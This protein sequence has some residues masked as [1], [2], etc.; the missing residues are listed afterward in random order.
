MDPGQV[1][2]GARSV[3]SLGVPYTASAPIRETTDTV[4]AARIA[5]FAQ[6]LDYHD[7]IRNRL[8]ALWAYLLQQAPGA[9]G[10]YYVDTGPVL[11]REL[12]QRAGLGW[13]GKNTCLINKRGGSFFFLAEIITDLALES[14]PPASSHCGTCRACLDAC[15]TRA[16]IA[17]NLLDARRCIA[18]LTIEHRGPIPRD[19]RPRMG[20]W[21]FGCDVCQQV[22]PW[23]RHPYAPDPAFHD[24]HPRDES[25]IEL[26]GLGPEEFN[27]IFRGTAVKRAKRRGFLRNVAVALGNWGQEPAVP[28]L[29]RALEDAEPLIRGHAAWAM[30]RIGSDRARAALLAA[31]DHEMDAD[32]REE[33]D[34]ALADSCPRAS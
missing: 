14:D 22:C 21:I 16:L 12:A 11:E 24:R 15:P 32:V 19:L 30:G 1:L 3:I 28:A 8:R 2:P 7:E 10:R 4:P 18:Y 27:R 31:R 9:R 26:M 33:I 25:L 5:T 34:W 20:Q 6:G 23:N 29:T 13:C 17:P